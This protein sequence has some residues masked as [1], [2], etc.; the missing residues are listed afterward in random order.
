MSWIFHKNKKKAWHFSREDGSVLCYETIL[1]DFLEN[2]IVLED[3]SL[4]YS[5][6][7]PADPD[8]PIQR[9]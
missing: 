8:S 7:K 6:T 5:R 2:V 3:E 4:S 1:L 9:L